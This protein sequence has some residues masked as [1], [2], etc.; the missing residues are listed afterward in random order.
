MKK[1]AIVLTLLLTTYAMGP[2]A[3]Q[4]AFHGFKAVSGATIDFTLA[5]T[6]KPFHQ[7]VVDP[8]SCTSGD[9]WFNTA[10][11]LLKTCISGVAT[12]AYAGQ[13]GAA[14][15]QSF[16]SQTSVVLLHNLNTLAVSVTCYDTS[17]PPL[18]IIPDSIA[19]TSTNSVTVTFVVA[20]SGN[21]VVRN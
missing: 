17:T 7:V 12:N 5:A 14:F 6:T 2:G 11:N 10:S 8:A 13:F 4:V 18:Y 15:S 16:A 9:W 1:T 21:C 20:Q 3:A 19:L